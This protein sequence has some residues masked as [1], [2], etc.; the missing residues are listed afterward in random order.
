[1]VHGIIAPVDQFGHGHELITSLFQC[2]NQGIK[3]L[4]CIPGTIVAQNDRT[5]SKMLILGD[6]LYD[7]V[8]TIVFPVET[9]NVPLDRIIIA[10]SRDLDE[11]CIIIAIRRTEQKHVIPGEFLHLVMHHHELFFLLSVGQLAHILVV[12]AVVSQ[13]VPFR[14]YH[15]Y[16]IGIGIHPHKWAYRKRDFYLFYHILQIHIPYFSRNQDRHPV[17]FHKL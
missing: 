9:V 14:E 17:F 15:L 10:L 3:R 2:R 1:M 6:G 8:H 13:I 4:H 7:G 12:L 16:I 11:L 5:I